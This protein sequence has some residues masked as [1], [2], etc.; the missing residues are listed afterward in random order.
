MARERVD[1]NNKDLFWSGV[2]FECLD[3]SITPK[4]PPEFMEEGLRF[5]GNTDVVV[6]GQFG[7]FVRGKDGVYLVAPVREPNWMV[8]PR[9]DRLLGTVLRE[10]FFENDGQERGI[11]VGGCMRAGKSEFLQALGEK[12]VELGCKIAFV[13][14]ERARAKDKH[15]Q[16]LD[17]YP[18]MVEL[19]SVKSIDEVVD[20]VGDSEADVVLWDEMNLLIFGPSRTFNSLQQK[21]EAIIRATQV[22]VGR[23]RKFVGA[24]LE[25][26]AT[27]EAFPPVEEALA[28]QRFDRRFDYVRMHAQCLCGAVAETQALTELWWWRGSFNNGGDCL[29]RP[30][31]PI[32]QEREA[33]EN[34]YA[35]VCSR[36]HNSA[37][38]GLATSKWTPLNLSGTRSFITLDLLQQL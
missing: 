15:Q 13:R 24:F 18:H 9:V 35:P 5:P 19:V 33:I 3:P 36:C 4:E 2:K 23:G 10:D 37:H 12:A 16:L 25:R 11:L 29:V 6:E 7:L 26:Y 22:I 34:F 8:R 14:P 20:R 27:G 17:Q 32:D 28:L 1:G 21:A 31:V 30:L 38:G